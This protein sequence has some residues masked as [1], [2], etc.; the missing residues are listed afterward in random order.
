[1]HDT[2]GRNRLR[3]AARTCFGEG[4]T[5]I[6]RAKNNQFRGEEKGKE[7]EEKDRDMAFDL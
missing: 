7:K 6:K 3:G 5:V 1:M 2:I 4:G